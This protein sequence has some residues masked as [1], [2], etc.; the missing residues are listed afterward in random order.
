MAKT[1]ET[2]SGEEKKLALATIKPADLKVLNELDAEIEKFKKEY[3]ELKIV[4]ENDK[5]GYE[6]VRAALSVMR[7]KRTALD[8]QRKKVT[9]PYRI[10]T[11]FYNEKFNLYIDS[12]AE[13]EEP[14]KARKKEIDDIQE[15]IKEQ[16]RLEEEMK[17]NDRINS[18]I[19]NGCAFDNSFYSIS[20]DEFGVS[21]ISLGVVDIRSMTD[22]AFKSFLQMVIDKNELIKSKQEEKQRKIEEELAEQKRKDDEAKEQLRK[23]QEKVEQQQKDMLAMKEKLDR[24]TFKNRSTQL[25]LMGFKA[26]YPDY[27]SVENIGIG[28]VAILSMEDDEWDK[29]VGD[30]ELQLNSIKKERQQT[31]MRNALLNSRAGMLLK[32]GMQYN[33]QNNIYAFENIEIAEQDVYDSTDEQFSNIV[34]STASKIEDRMKEV[35]EQKEQDRIAEEKRI[36]DKAIADKEAVEKAEAEKKQLEMEQAKDSDKFLHLISELQ[37]I[38]MPEM[39]SA[40][41]KK[42]VSDIENFINSIV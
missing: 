38:R 39:K 11:K 19:T 3:G 29:T 7:P 6:K 9:E 31:E 34:I 10:A 1:T 22:D 4:D 27:F 33:S 40:K 13:V 26:E 30:F 17:I 20:N 36:T 24:Q 14:L 41:Y 25:T 37:S 12:I 28:K 23:D 21:E 16:K 32:I 5:E 2:T 15:Q 42:K 8:E 35:A 18:L